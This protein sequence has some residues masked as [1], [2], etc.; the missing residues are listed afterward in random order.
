MTLDGVPVAPAARLTGWLPAEDGWQWTDGMATLATGGARQFRLTVLLHLGRYWQEQPSVPLA[1]LSTALYAHTA[2]RVAVGRGPCQRPQ[3]GNARPG[4]RVQRGQR[5]GR[6][7][8][9]AVRR[10]S[11]RPRWGKV[12]RRRQ[13]A[14]GPSEPR[15]RTHGKRCVAMMRLTTARAAVRRRRTDHDRP[16]T[17][18]NVGD[19]GDGQG[20]LADGELVHR[21]PITGRR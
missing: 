10:G 12:R 2:I 20:S 19:V 1:A 11:H 4:L 13:I 18:G 16:P 8:G 6:A 3:D 9:R 5:R 14:R 15:D 7:P 21:P 17:A